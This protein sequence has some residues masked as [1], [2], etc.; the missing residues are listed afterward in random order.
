MMDPW[1]TEILR[2]QI[3]SLNNHIKADTSYLIP[4][5]VS[6]ILGLSV[7]EVKHA[8]Q[9]GKLPRQQFPSDGH[10]PPP[11]VTVVKDTRREEILH[12]LGRGRNCP[13]Q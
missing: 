4:G 8:G 10:A 7:Q 2:S 12:V 1:M 11:G 3:S 6:P 5:S 9:H 13:G